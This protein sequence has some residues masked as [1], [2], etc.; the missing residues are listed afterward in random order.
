VHGGGR[1]ED[2]TPQNRKACEEL[3]GIKYEHCFGRNSIGYK[4]KEEK[5]MVKR[6][7]RDELQGKINGNS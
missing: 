7:H 5:K 4:T 1:I 3:T 2:V 6:I